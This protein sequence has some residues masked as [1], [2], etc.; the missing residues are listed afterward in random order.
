MVS[1]MDDYVQVRKDQVA[2]DDHSGVKVRME[3]NRVAG[4]VGTVSSST[5]GS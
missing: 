2:G 1:S 5:C 4:S 3:S